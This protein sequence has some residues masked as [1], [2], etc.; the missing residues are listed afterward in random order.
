MNRDIGGNLII[1]GYFGGSADFD[2]G[3]GTFIKTYTD[4]IQAARIL[5]Q[6]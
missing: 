3:P 6:G 4:T 2:P 5:E 1:T